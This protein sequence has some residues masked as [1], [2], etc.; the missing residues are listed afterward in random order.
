MIRF[1][2]HKIVL[3]VFVLLLCI[4]LRC[5][6]SSAETANSPPITITVPEKTIHN[7][8]M[9]LLPYEIPMGENFSGTLWVQTIDRLKIGTNHVVFFM[10]VLGKDIAFSTTVGKRIINLKF[11]QANISSVCE[12]AFR[13]DKVKKILYITPQIKEFIDADQA[14]QAGE[15]LMLLLKGLSNIEYAIDLGRIDP[16]EKKLQDKILT[17]HF[18]IFDIYSEDNQVFVKLVPFVGTHVAATPNK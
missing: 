10:K 5:E 17:I 14:G 13:Y 2:S 6:H 4:S 18:E 12:A 1:F 16:I 8:I 11:G 9:D 3:S 15:A 7:S